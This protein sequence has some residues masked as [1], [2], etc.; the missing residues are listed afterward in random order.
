MRIVLKLSPA[1][2]IIPFDH[3]PLLV[4]CIHRW[5]E[6]NKQ[7]YDGHVALFSFSKLNGGHRSNDGLSF[8]NG[9]DFFLSSYNLSLIKQLIKGIRKDPKMFYGLTVT[10]IILER[11]SDMD[12]REV[13]EVASP[14]LISRRINDRI[15]QI[16]Y[17]DSRASDFLKE[18]I[19][20]KMKYAGLEIDNSFYIKFDMTYPKA[21][22]KMINYK[23]IYNRASWCPVIITGDPQTKLFIWN[24]GVG[25]STG[26][27]FGAIR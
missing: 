1:A 14:I 13:F 16:L 7:F 5:L 2:E 23:E 15:E 20:T 21:S 3:Q 22:T 25:N 11:D 4:D 10:D 19:Q 9:A 17:N 18:T 6:W 24:V 27:G 8:S 12:T 26:I